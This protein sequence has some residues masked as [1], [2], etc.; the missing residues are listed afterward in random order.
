MIHLYITLEIVCC[1][2]YT[3]VGP[4]GTAG[5]QAIGR[6]EHCGQCKFCERN[7]LGG[8]D[9]SYRK[10]FLLPQIMQKPAIAFKRQYDE[11]AAADAIDEA[12]EDMVME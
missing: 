8:G 5:I 4:T 3:G 7:A 10:M 9:I 12:N 1:Q 6:V 11:A 2:H